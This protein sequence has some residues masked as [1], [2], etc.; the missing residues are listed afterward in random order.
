M[1]RVIHLLGGLIAQLNFDSITSARELAT[2]SHCH[3][4][5]EPSRRSLGD[6][7]ML[8]CPEP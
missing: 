4:P 3:L 5:P 6:C 2:Y 7:N 8:R 1:L